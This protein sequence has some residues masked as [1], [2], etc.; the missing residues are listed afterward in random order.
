MIKPGGINIITDP[1]LGE[2]EAHSSTCRH[3]QHITDFPSR[4]VMMDHVDLCFKCMELVCR[5][6]ACQHRGCVPYEKQAEL[7]ENEYKLRSRIHL[8]GW[9]CY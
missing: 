6:P 8:Q 1:D 4:K 9:R 5:Q 7:Q 2:V 3:C